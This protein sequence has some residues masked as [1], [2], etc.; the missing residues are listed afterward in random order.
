MLEEEGV[1]F[2][3]DKVSGSA[4]VHVFSSPLAGGDKGAQS[5]GK[6]KRKAASTEGEGVK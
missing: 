3:N 2:T 6:R 4:F 1:R 5:S